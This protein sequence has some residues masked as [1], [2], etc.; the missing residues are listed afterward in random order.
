MSEKTINQTSLSQNNRI[1][2]VSW[3]QFIGVMSVIFGHS[4]NSIAVPQIW[5]D[6]KAWVY[7]WHMPLF[8]LVSAFLF[9]YKGG[10]DKG[11]KKVF[12]N[13]FV[14]LIIPYIIWNLAFVVPKIIFAPYINDQVSLD[15]S[16]LIRILLRPRDNILGHTWFLAA[17]FEMFVI[18]IFLEKIRK[19][20][21]LW[22]P[23]GCVL[24]VTYCFG[25]LN[26]FLAVGDLMKNGIFF[27]VG[28]MLGGYGPK[29]IQECLRDKAFFATVALVVASS[30]VVWAYNPDMKINTLL[31]GMMS[32][33]LFVAIQVN[34]NINFRYMDFVSRNAFPI[35]I[36]HWPVM[37]IIRLIVYTK[38]NMDPV[39]TMVIMLIGGI[40]IPSAITWI[41]TKFK[42]KFMRNICRVVFGM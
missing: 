12:S 26:R 19:N 23:V 35:Y 5:V 15:V 14:R 29:K 31:L 22:I 38:L 6:I 11:Y 17:L 18:A 13:R 1:D 41:L 10:F 4:M 33:V 9:S 27:W 8:F 21:K 32:L 20:K 2:F 25:V 42:S 40:V 36:L 28:L 34:F 3:I 39:V 30:T 16:Y 37:M 24:I 7:T